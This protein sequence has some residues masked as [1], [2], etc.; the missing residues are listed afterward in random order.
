M[1]FTLS[2]LNS[3]SWKALSETTVGRGARDVAKRG[4]CSVYERSVKTLHNYTIRHPSRF[5]LVSNEGQHCCSVSKYW[6]LSV[7]RSIRKQ[8]SA[9]V[10]TGSRDVAKRGQCMHYIRTKRKKT[11][12]LHYTSF[13]SLHSDLKRRPALLFSFQ[14]L[15]YISRTF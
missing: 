12:Y 10:S 11:S 8:Q 2:T 14:I 3:T 5:I 1:P 7:G 4:Q 13:K 15:N 9:T 6:I